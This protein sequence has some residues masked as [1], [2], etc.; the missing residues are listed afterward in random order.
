[1]SWI[2]RLDRSLLGA[3]LVAGFAWYER[4]PPD[5]AR[6]RAGRDARRAGRARP[7][8]LRAD[9]ERQADDRHRAARRLRARRR[10]RLRGRRRR[11]AG[12]ELLLRPGA[13]DAV[14]DGGAGA[15]VGVVGAA[16]RARCA[17]G[18][19]AA[20]RSRSPARSPALVFGA[21]MNLHLWVTYSGDHTPRQARR[22]LRDLAAVRPR[23][24]GRQR[25]LLPGLRA[26]RSCARCSASGRAWRSRWIPAGAS[27]APRCSPLVLALGRAR[28]PAPRAERRRG[29]RQGVAALPGRR[30][31]RRRR[32]RRRARPVLDAAAHRL[33]GARA[34]G[35]RAATRSTSAATD[36]DRLHAPPRRRAGR[37]RRA[38]AHDPR[39][40]RRRALAARRRRP[41]PRRAS[42][43]AS[44]SATA[45]SPAA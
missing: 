26:R 40:R 20:S 15:L 18:R 29:G 32:L 16:A 45:P 31:E 36:R 10:A 42:C 21:V 3:A 41:R 17:R 44:A 34:R 8:R 1:M 2:A 35:R 5:L 19:S 14:A 11:R 37:P 23:A 25:R 30:P 4:T 24:R 12:L 28:R 13:V 7:D 33:D 43:C 38:L 27:R 6:A 22:L 39:L 9:P